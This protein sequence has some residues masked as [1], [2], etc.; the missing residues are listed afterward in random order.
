[1]ELLTALAV[2]PASFGLA[3]L[4]Q[5]GTLKIIFWALQCMSGS[6]GD[7]GIQTPAAPVR[8]R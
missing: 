7:S 4:L 5:F 6:S 8:G 1:M 3:L 2:I